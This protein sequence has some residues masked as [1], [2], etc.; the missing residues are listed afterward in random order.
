M[1]NAVIKKLANE[2]GIGEEELEK[3]WKA[4]ASSGKAK[5]LAKSNYEAYANAAV[6]HAAKAKGMDSDRYIDANGCLICPNSIITGSDVA[7]YWGREIP[8][9]KKLGL[10]PQKIYRVYRPIEE[11]DSTETFSGKYIFTHHLLDY[12]AT[13]MED[14]RKHIIGTA[15]DC[16]QV[17]TEVHGTVSFTDVKAI[18]DLDNGKK[19]LSAGYWYDPILEVGV[20]EGQ[21]YDIKM[22]NIKANHIAHV[23]NPRYKKAV[24]GDE[25]TTNNKAN[26][27]KYKN[28][29]LNALMTKLKAKGLDEETTKT[30]EEE[31]KAADEEVTE[32]AAP[33]AAGKAQDN[34]SEGNKK[35]GDED[36]EDKKKAADEHSDEKE[37]SKLI[38]KTLK[39]KGLDEDSFNRRLK[40]ATEASLNEF[41][42]QAKAM[43]SAFDAFET[44]YGKANKMAFDSPD[45]VYDAILQRNGMETKGRTLDAKMGM[46]EVILGQQ[47]PARRTM[48]AD[49]DSGANY[50]S[51]YETNG[52]LKRFN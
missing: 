21:P 27:M 3:I 13:T 8:N 35:A 36:D 42:A 15:Y 48:A 17:G 41:K 16:I 22:T 44:L 25:D 39:E 11:L 32:T 34:D 33:G 45:A 5:G 40:A 31:A 26:V 37:D 18:E 47:K 29:A 23:D 20:F 50:K 19:Y 14:A 2:S 52:A 10:D 12:D 28:K 7:N 49:T 9:Y 46:V 4:A 30:L 6:H 43:D 1:P 51:I 38:E 24:V